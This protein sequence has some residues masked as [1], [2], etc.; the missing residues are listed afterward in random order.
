MSEAPVE[1]LKERT[2]PELLAPAGSLE[3]CKIAF[4]YGAD[5]VYVGPKRFSLRAYARNLSDEELAEAACL[6]HAL[7]RKI[8]VTVNTFARESD[9]DMLPPFLRYLQDIGADGVIISDPG[10]LTLAKKWCPRVPIH[11]STQS[12]TT[13]SLSARF[14][15]GFGVHRVNLAR[16]LTFEEIE[17]IAACSSIELETFVHGAMCMSYSGR[18]LLSSYLNQ[19]SANQGLCSQ[20]CRWAY[21][22]VEEKR[23]GQFFPIR[24][25]P[26]G[27]YIF[28]SKDLCL[29]ADLGR[30][31]EM[32]I[33]AFK[34]EGRMKGALYLATVV[35]TY[36]QAIDEFWDSP[37]T[38]EPRDEWMEDLRCVSHRPYTS[39][40][41]FPDRSDS[42]GESI[43]S[44]AC[45]QTHTLA[46][47]VRAHPETA[48]C[49]ESSRSTQPGGHVCMEVR[50]RLVEGARLQFLFPDGT[51][52]DHVL[53]EFKDL[54]GSDLRVAHPNTWIQF[55]TP[56][57]TF[58]LQVVRCIQLQSQ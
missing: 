16:E 41:L 13:N 49:R 8:Y 19:R 34:I 18:C 47:I 29:L 39:G 33:R 20:P 31:M 9:L 17:R 23:P 26:H 27:T 38:Y 52:L 45:V 22:L 32:G 35:R 46:G 43:N 1:L 10:V 4:L 50:S 7:G 2:R 44:A 53:H 57:S 3:K 14:W 58:P 40:F 30:L 12:N 15:Q 5:A 48:V 11:L 42:L 6:S 54:R 51:T 28:N 36:R 56:F 55:K 24:E 21:A 25:D 37:K